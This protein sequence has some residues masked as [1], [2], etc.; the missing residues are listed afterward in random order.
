MDSPVY[1]LKP[2]VS[3]SGLALVLHFQADVI[4]ADVAISCRIFGHCCKSNGG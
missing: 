4:L 2:G 3:C 1:Y